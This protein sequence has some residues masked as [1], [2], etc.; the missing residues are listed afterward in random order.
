VDN[1]KMDIRELG[2]DGMDDDDNNNNNNNNNNN[3]F[4]TYLNA[5]TTSSDQL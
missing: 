5:R 4:F 1:I 3:K 2:W